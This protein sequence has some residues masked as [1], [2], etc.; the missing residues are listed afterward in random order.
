MNVQA[1]LSPREGSFS[2][3]Q[4]QKAEPGVFYA[5]NN[6]GVFRSANS[7]LSWEALPVPWPAGTRFGRAHAIVVMPE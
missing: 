6:H 7:G 5:A 1:F 4:F 2:P 3:A